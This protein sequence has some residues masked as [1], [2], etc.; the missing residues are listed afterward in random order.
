MWGYM[1]RLDINRHG[2]GFGR[3]GRWNVDGGMDAVV[4][5]IS[6]YGLGWGV[7]RGW[8]WESDDGVGFCLLF[9]CCG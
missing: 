9:D 7:G 2:Y 8:W 4:G 6:A 3:C 5:V 1:L